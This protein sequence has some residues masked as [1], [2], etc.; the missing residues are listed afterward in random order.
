MAKKNISL[1]MKPEQ[2]TGIKAA[3]RAKLA[4]KIARVLAS[5]YLLGLKTQ[6]C[7]WNVTGPHFH[8]LHGMFE[9]QYNAIAAANDVLAE[10]IRAL[11]HAAPG[12][13]REFSKLA[14]LKEEPLEKPQSMLQALLADHEKMAT[15]CRKVM[16]AGEEAGDGATHD[17]MIERLDFHEKTAW[18]L[19][20][21]LS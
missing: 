8:S 11:G 7:H 1:V 13:F 15:E 14:F 3:S 12:S 16:E 18:M 9:E 6:N 4:E 21:T 2:D 10:R 19:R 5:N 20:A 17:L